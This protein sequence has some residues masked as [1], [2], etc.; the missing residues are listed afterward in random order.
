ML[1]RASVLALVDLTT[2]DYQLILRYGQHGPHFG[3]AP[4]VPRWQREGRSASQCGL[5]NGG[6][7]ARERRSTGWMG[8]RIEVASKL[9]SQPNLCVVGGGRHTVQ[10]NDKRPTITQS[11]TNVLRMPHA[12]RKKTSES[13]RDV[14][15]Y[16]LVC[17]CT[18]KHVHA[19]HP[20]CQTV[21]S[22][23]SHLSAIGEEL[24]GA[25]RGDVEVAILAQAPRKPAERERLS[26]HRDTDI[27]S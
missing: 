24:H 12:S 20:S 4:H 10:C 23:S 17:V 3:S 7:E 13:D 26:R 2:P 16:H 6:W 27:Y 14:S 1:G 19:S 18:R 15:K 5:G 25:F 9:H 8:G 11:E 21:S 22:L